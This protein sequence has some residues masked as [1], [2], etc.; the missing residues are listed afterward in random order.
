MLSKLFKLLL[1]L[2]LLAIVIVVGNAVFFDLPA[3][4][5]DITIVVEPSNG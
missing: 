2:A 1:I 4:S 3:P 5:R